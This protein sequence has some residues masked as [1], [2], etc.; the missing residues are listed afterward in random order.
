[1]KSL[2]FTS[3]LGVALLAASAD[4]QSAPQSVFVRNSEVFIS[5]LLVF[6]LLMIGYTGLVGERAFA[7]DVPSVSDKVDLQT[8]QKWNESDQVAAIKWHLARGMPPSD[9]WTGLMLSKRSIALPLIEQKIEQV[10]TSASPSECFTEKSV[11]TEKFI[12]LA[13]SAIIYKG[14]ELSLRQV[15]KLIR[16]DGKRFGDLVARTLME[17]EGSLNPF[18]VAYS[19]F[20]IGDPALDQ[21]IGAWAEVELAEVEQVGTW[22]GPETRPMPFARKSQVRIWWTEALVARY[23][24]VP[25]EDEWRRDP[26]VS[27]LEPS[28][29]TLLHDDMIRRAVELVE[30]RKK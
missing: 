17:A 5:Y 9:V 10:L 12:V 30:K 28:R 1:M 18:V 2:V 16:L 3:F 4:E 29:A 15:S 20:K 21:K 11:D 23:G 14:D 7:Q 22:H 26:I 25:T 24:S 8:V 19:G 27:R 6:T 13:T